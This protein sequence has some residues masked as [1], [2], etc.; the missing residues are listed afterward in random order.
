MFGFLPDPPGVNDVRALARR[1]D[2]ARHHGV[3]KGCVLEAD[4][5]AAPPETGGLDPL[6]IISGGGRPLVL[7]E[8]GPPTI[9]GS[10]G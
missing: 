7:R 6:A 4:L 5:H 9:R 3:P 2:T 1:V 8:A 10:P